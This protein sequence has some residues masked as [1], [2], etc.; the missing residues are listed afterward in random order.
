[1]RLSEVRWLKTSDAATDKTLDFA[2]REL[3][4]YGAKITGT[5]WRAQGAYAVE[6]AP[7][8]IWLGLCDWLPQPPGA[9]LTPSLLDDGYAIWGAEGGVA[10]AGRNARSVLFG[11]YAYLE[12]QGV[13]YV[14]P[15]PDGE[16]IPRFKELDAPESPIRELAAYRHRG[17]CIE[18]APS[19]DHALGMVDWCAKRRM[20][21]L[22]LQFF[23]SQYF[24]Q[25]WYGKRYNPERK[26]HDVSEAEA[27]ALDL[28]VIASLK[29]RGL[30][31]H[32]V[33]H[34]WTALTLGLPRSGWV[35][36]DEPVPADRQRWVAETGG[37]RKLF[38]DMP[39]NT[40]L[41]YSF[42]PAFDAF[43][44]EIARY[45]SAHPEVD[46]VH[47][48]L[49]DAMNN[50]CECDDCRTLSIADWYAKLVNA[51]SVALQ[52]RAPGKRFVFLCY[53]ELWWPPEQVIMDDRYGNAIM[54][55]APIRRCYG[56]DLFSDACAEEG[57]A[58]RPPVNQTV[59][60][61]TNRA[62]AE[63]L[64]AWRKVFQGDSFDF[65]YHLMWAV[66]RQMTDTVVA[67]VFWEDLQGLK[68]AGLD[69]IVSCQPFRNFYPSGLAMAAL[70]EALWNPSVSWEALRRGY[71]EAAYGD[72]A[73]WVD[74]YLDRLESLLQ[75]AETAHARALPLLDADDARL[76]ELEQLIADASASLS[77]RQELTQN[78]VHR[79]S[80]DILAYHARLLA[81]MAAA[82]RA[83]RAGDKERAMKALDQAADFLRR[84]EGRYHRYIDTYLVLSQV[85]EA[86]RK[87]L[88]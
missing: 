85:V 70:A 23:N 61:I 49:S 32:Q 51:L 55:F 48:W 13:R 24:Y 47:V 39:I 21:T 58:P 19:L 76:A 62:Y 88:G 52:Q 83:H 35:T 63:S 44:E 64:A 34:G 87:A 72:S 29:T 25:L 22:F 66:W 75:V 41:C 12:S 80:L 18:G 46:V 14:R 10:I 53:F 1:M 38:R 6:P 3:A 30:V 8:T 74:G 37:A 4:R 54:M 86:T 73:A 27:R 45:S 20:N 79:R 43:V 9:E 42:Q 33:G 56:H 60:P 11:V 5:D 28:E 50:K 31:L 40:E 65:D 78:E 67:R 2:A 16:V 36:T 26:D 17:L 84:T 59:A 68:A 57:L 71:L 77:A 69:G 15:G 7:G 81:Y 82:H